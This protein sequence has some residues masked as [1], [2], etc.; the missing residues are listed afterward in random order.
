[1]I[2]VDRA[3]A[4]RERAGKPIRVGLVGAGFAGKG[5]ALQLLG[6]LPGLRLVCISNRTLTEAEAAYRMADVNECEHVKTPEQLRADVLIAPH[7]GSSESLTD[8][9]LA[10]VGATSI[11]SSND[12]TLSQKQVRFEALAGGATL[13]RTHRC[14][15]ITVTLHLD[16]SIRVEPYLNPR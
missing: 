10:A 8:E 16:G 1:M 6:N 2:V 5:F 3:L 13:Y 14:G 15:A 11:I 9:F 4:E 7:H 12:R